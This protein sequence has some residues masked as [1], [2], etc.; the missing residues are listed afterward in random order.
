[1]QRDPGGETDPFFGADTG[2][3]ASEERGGGGAA[4]G[5]SQ[6]WSEEERSRPSGRWGRGGDPGAEAAPKLPGSGD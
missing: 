3:E 5:W 1:M 6:G 2:D 4:A